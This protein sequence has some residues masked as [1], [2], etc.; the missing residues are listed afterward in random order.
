[1]TTLESKEFTVALTGEGFRIVSEG[2]HNSADEDNHLRAPNSEGGVFET[3]YSLLGSI[4]PGFRFL[5]R[6]ISCIY[7]SI[8]DIMLF[9]YRDA[10]GRRLSF[11]LEEVFKSQQKEEKAKQS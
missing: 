6:T 11:K 1:M 10:F 5:S 3:P 2:K 8:P 4:S 7:G 9:R